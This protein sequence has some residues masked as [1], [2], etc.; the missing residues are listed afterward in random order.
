MPLIVQLT[1][2]S[3]A[4]NAV[5]VSL[6][7]CQSKADARLVLLIDWSAPKSL[8]GYGRILEQMRR[9]SRFGLLMD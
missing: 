2:A 5:K 6:L 4:D 7:D 1:S 3:G 9:L 8:S